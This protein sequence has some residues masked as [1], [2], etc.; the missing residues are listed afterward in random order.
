V[1]NKNIKIKKVSFGGREVE[2]VLERKNVKNVNLRVRP[3]GSVYVSAN[4][5]VSEKYI[6]KFLMEKGDFILGA[7][8]RYARLAKE[9]PPPQGY[10]DGDTVT[11]FGRKYK[12]CSVMGVKNT[13]DIRGDALILTMLKNREEERRQLVENFLLD[14]CRQAVT[15]LCREEYPRF[16]ALGVA[17]P[18]IKFRRMKSRWGSCQP[19]KGVLTFNYELSA[20]PYECVRYVVLHEFTH[21]LHPDHSAAFHRRLTAFMPEAAER[22]RELEAYGVRL[23]LKN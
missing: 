18:R 14:A 2:Y 20:V 5:G 13:A 6:E 4:R 3:D 16:E 7:I 8:D 19:K 11:V 22:K 10:C 12:I 23:R 1:K 17:F 9:A 21:F 15:A